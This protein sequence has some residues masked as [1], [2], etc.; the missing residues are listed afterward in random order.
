MA[1]KLVRALLLCKGESAKGAPGV[2]V[3]WGGA[4]KIQSPLRSGKVY[5]IRFN[6]FSANFLIFLLFVSN[7]NHAESQEDWDEGGVH[8]ASP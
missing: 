4:I 5:Q 7:Y 2:C 6:L 1:W 3:G 8:I